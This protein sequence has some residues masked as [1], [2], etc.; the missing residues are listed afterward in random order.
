[1]STLAAPAPA[2]VREAASRAGRPLRILLIGE[3]HVRGKV[4]RH[5]AQLEESRGIETHYFVDDR[6]GIT[7][8]EAKRTPMRVHWAPNP[9]AGRTGVL[10]YWAA[11]RRC[12]AEVRPD[13][14]EVYTSINFLVLFPMLLY[15]ALR[16]VPRVVMCRGELYPP[17]FEKYSPLQR[18]LF[19]RM[20]RMSQLVVFKELYMEEQ[21][22]RLCPSVPRLFWANAIP[23][24]PEP[25]TYARAGDEVLFLNFFKEWRNL[26]LVVRAAAR[27][28]KEVPGARFRLVGGTGNLAQ[29]GVF[30]AGL[31]DYERT[32][33]ELI[34]EL[35]LRDSVEVLP[36]T[37]EVEP[38]YAAAKLYLLPADL[39]FCNYALLEAMERGVPP[40][41]SADRDPNARR[42]VEDGVSGRVVP[43]DDAALADAIVGLLQDEPRRQAL[44]RGAR[45]K[46]AQDFD[47][48]RWIES[49]AD[50]Y[51][52]LAARRR[53]AAAG[54]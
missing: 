37:G 1:V 46:V 3:E 40:I 18:R 17:V 14:V 11:F 41:V 21:L 52:A 36:F 27:V 10:A 38:Y 54:G 2:A 47:L 25:A 43:L 4:A 16:G 29:A 9:A 6:S 34:D 24:R 45:A 13:V 22:A 35:G 7:R 31:N 19:I 15:A 20:L 32:I 33:L 42:I 44:A 26:D 12:F 39:V 53:P 23:I 28:V 49:L 5:Y 50:A 8:E 48:D 30:Y 51:T